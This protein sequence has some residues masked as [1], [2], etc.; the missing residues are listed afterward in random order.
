M[1]NNLFLN[2][3]TAYFFLPWLDLDFSV[4]QESQAISD[5][6]PPALSPFWYEG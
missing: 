3:D 6:P 5:T 1:L 4:L 2:K